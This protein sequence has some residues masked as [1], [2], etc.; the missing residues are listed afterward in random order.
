MGSVPPLLQ[1]YGPLRLP[2]AL[3]ATLQF[4][5]P[6]GTASRPPLRSHGL[7]APLPHGPGV[8]STGLPTPASLRGNDR[9]SQVPGEPP[10]PMPCSPTP[11]GPPRQAILGASVLPSAPLT[12]SAPTIN[13]FRGSI[14]R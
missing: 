4:P 5:W 3:P 8:C 2:A 6:D 1:Y 12:T 14:T 10:V 9:V 7:R 13:P 11:M